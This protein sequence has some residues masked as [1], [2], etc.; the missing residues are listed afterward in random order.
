MT[1][2]QITEEFVLVMKFIGE[3]RL[4]VETCR[5]ALAVLGIPQEK[6]DQMRAEME[7]RWKA[8]MDPILE[9]V[10]DRRT[11]SALEAE[12]RRRGRPPQ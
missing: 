8:S 3:L 6:F 12:L 7:S 2:E 1:R 9:R 4:D 5:A 11:L 10:R